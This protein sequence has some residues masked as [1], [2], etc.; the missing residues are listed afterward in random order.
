[1]ILPQT[2]IITQ[3]FLIPDSASAHINDLTASSTHHPAQRAVVVPEEEWE[4]DQ[5]LGCRRFRG[6]LRYLVAWQGYPPSW[7]PSKNLKNCGDLVRA[8]HTENLRY[9]R[10][11][12][13]NLVRVRTVGSGSHHVAGGSIQIRSVCIRKLL[14]SFGG[15]NLEA[16]LCRSRT[17]IASLG[18]TSPGDIASA[19]S[20]ALSYQN[21][22]STVGF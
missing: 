15:V 16:P 7:Q 11:C 5:I 2:P 6:K 13:A 12:G 1:M 19:H 10:S 17:S 21:S 8:F 20:T 18:D 4:V 14:P 3:S 22:P 9:H